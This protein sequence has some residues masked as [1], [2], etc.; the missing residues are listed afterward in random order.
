M[1][2]GTTASTIS[3]TADEPITPDDLTKKNKDYYLAVAHNNTVQL[4]KEVKEGFTKID[5]RFT[6]MEK[7]I[8]SRFTELSQKFDTVCKQV[9]SSDVEVSDIRNETENLKKEFQE[10]KKKNESK[11]EVETKSKTEIKKT[12]INSQTEI[13]K[14]EIV[15]NANVKMAITTLIS[16][17][18]GGAITALVIILTGGT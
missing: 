9:S 5:G 11:A 10:F 12:K 13:K 15:S 18:L 14:T 2:N 16:S 6:D 4:R 3:Q 8:N 17:V 1:P 7:N